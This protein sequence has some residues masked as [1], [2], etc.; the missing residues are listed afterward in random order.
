MVKIRVFNNM[1]QFSWFS[2]FRVLNLEISKKVFDAFNYPLWDQNPLW[3]N[4]PIILNS[5]HL[6]IFLKRFLIKGFSHFLHFTCRIAWISMH[7]FTW[8]TRHVVLGRLRSTWTLRLWSIFVAG[9]YFRSFLSKLKDCE[10]HYLARGDSIRKIHFL[11]NI[12]WMV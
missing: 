5:N 1:L 6:Q 12:L 2:R 11:N 4:E 3:R 7:V 9:P 8:L 10:I